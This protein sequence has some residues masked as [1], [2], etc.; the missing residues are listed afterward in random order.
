MSTDIEYV[1]VTK[2][3]VSKPSRKTQ[4]L[5]KAKVMINCCAKHFMS[6]FLEVSRSLVRIESSFHERSS[7]DQSFL[8]IN[9]C[10]WYISTSPV[11]GKQGMRVLVRA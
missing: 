6:T 2:L 11:P 5:D 4:S 7:P 3:A 10:L 8:Y 1:G 9:T